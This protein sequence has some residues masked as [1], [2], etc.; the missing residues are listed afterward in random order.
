MISLHRVA[1]VTLNNGKRN[2]TVIGNEEQLDEN[3]KR[4]R[5]GRTLEKGMTKGIE[6]EEQLE[7]ERQK[8]LEGKTNL[9]RNGKTK[10]KGEQLEEERQQEKKGKKH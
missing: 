10:G 1:I 9:K 7:E 2:S 5:K 4:N 6:K 8:K 3:S